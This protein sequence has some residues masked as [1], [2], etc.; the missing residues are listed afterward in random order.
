M[1]NITKYDLNKM[2]TSDLELS[3]NCPYCRKQRLS[4]RDNKEYE[5]EC[6]KCRCMIILD[7]LSL[8]VIKNNNNS[9]IDDAENTCAIT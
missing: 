5:I 7:G 8:A 2:R 3:F 4:M 6:P 9:M 1:G